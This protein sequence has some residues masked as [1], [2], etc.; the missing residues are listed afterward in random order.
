MLEITD[1]NFKSEVLD[2]TGVVLVDF[3][4]VW[5]GPCRALAP[6]V[7][8]IAEEYAGKV[9]VGKL[10]TEA[11]PDTAAQMGVMAIPTLLFFKDGEL[12]QKTTGLVSKSKIAQILDS[13][14]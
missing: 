5:C 9:K 11:N 3:W 2:A 1:Q 7:E 8:Q 14:L 13:L 10:D 6:F 12:K 4:A